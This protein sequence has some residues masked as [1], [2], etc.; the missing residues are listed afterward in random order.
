MYSETGYTQTSY[1]TPARYYL[2]SACERLQYIMQE[3]ATDRQAS[4][5]APC[6]YLVSFSIPITVFV[7]KLKWRFC[8]LL[9][10]IASANRK[11]QENEH[12]FNCLSKIGHLNA[13]FWILTL[14]W[15]LHFIRCESMKP[16]RC[17][18]DSS[19]QLTR[20]LA[21]SHQWS[22]YSSFR[23]KY[24]SC[25]LLTEL[26]LKSLWSNCVSWLPEV[27]G[28]PSAIFSLTSRSRSLWIRDLKKNG[29]LIVMTS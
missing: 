1:C 23:Y 14:V 18:T 25:V 15:F 26:W 10:N 28:R 7:W 27:L 3:F 20:K 24:K 21:T 4:A 8:G 11:V 22:F 12:F 19:C 5:Q 13:H 29:L 9:I 6:P 16:G 2:V 17:S